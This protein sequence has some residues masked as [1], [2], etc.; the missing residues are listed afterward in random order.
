[1]LRITVSLAVYMLWVGFSSPCDAVDLLVPAQ[2][3]TIQGAI[4]AANPGDTL[5]VAAGTYTGGIDFLGKAI[6]VTS[7]AGPL[8]TTIDAAGG[9]VAVLFD[10]STTGPA[11]LEG[12]TVTNGT[13]AGIAGS[14]GGILVLGTGVT[15]TRNII[16]GNTAVS[17]GGVFCGSSSGALFVNNI[18]ANNN[19]SIGGG[20]YSDSTLEIVMTQN[21]IVDNSASVEG[22]GVYVIGNDLDIFNSILWGNTAPINPQIAETNVFS[23]EHCDIEGGYPAAFGNFGADPLFVNQAAGD[24][25]LLAGSPC[26]NTGDSAVPFLPLDDFDGAVRTCGPDI[27]AFELPE[28]A[29]GCVT[30]TIRGDCNLSANINIA[31]AIF[32]LSIL[33]PSSNPPQASCLDLE[34]ADDCERGAG[35]SSQ[36]EEHQGD[37]PEEV[38]A[39]GATMRQSRV[40]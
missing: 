32:A 17:G 25:H 30:P 7:D 40:K 24:F 5:R 18:I 19:A 26:E 20:I 23:C 14:G 9:P 12:F 6:T 33:F 31:D 4:D 34:S 10:S 13:G 39:D 8:V 38:L 21:T 37:R 36:D 3:A 29:G 28:P 11:A 2:H 1:M 22:G 15:V 27:G 16:V 35:D